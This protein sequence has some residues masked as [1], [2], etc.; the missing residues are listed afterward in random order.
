MEFTYFVSV[1]EIGAQGETSEEGENKSKVKSQS[2][3]C[4]H[5]S[6]KAPDPIRTPQLN[7][8]GRE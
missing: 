6:T 5:T 8:L 1:P 7:V 3:E 2:D 4:D